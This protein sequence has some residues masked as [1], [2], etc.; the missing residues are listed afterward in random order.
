MS[1][2][3]PQKTT[4]NDSPEPLYRFQEK[5]CL[6]E[7]AQ[8]EFETLND[9]HGI[10]KQ[11]II[12]E[13]TLHHTQLSTTDIKGKE[14]Y[15]QDLITRRARTVARIHEETRGGAR[16]V[17][18]GKVQEVL[19]YYR[20]GWSGFSTNARGRVR[21]RDVHPAVFTIVLSTDDGSLVPFAHLDASP[22]VVANPN[23]YSQKDGISLEERVGEAKRRI[24]QQ[25]AKVRMVYESHLLKKGI[26]AT[27]EQ[28]SLGTQI[29]LKRGSVPY[30]RRL[31]DIKKKT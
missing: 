27:N 19:V 8:K 22:I 12:S 28:Y 26:R 25:V 3:I 20:P 14:P 7:A 17:D 9:V 24:E 11:Y 29:R 4:L 31:V 21:D 2:S 23:S 1:E 16:E 13:A 6:T 10:A 18:L 5:N 15:L 30:W